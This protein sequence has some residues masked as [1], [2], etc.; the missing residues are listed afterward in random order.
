MEGLVVLIASLIGLA[1][2]AGPIFSVLGFVRSRDTRKRLEEL[3]RTVE[4]LERRVVELSKRDAAPATAATAQAPTPVAAS[5]PAVAPPRRTPPPAPTPIPIPPPVTATA[6][7]APLWTPPPPHV[8]SPRPPTPPPRVEPPPEPPPAP[9]APAFDWESML[10]VRGA[11]WMGGITLVIAAA[12]FAKWSIDQGFFSPAIRIAMMLLAGTGALAWAEL[13]LREGFH[14]TANAVSGAG[15]VT[16]YLAFFAAHSLYQLFGLTVTFAAMMLV[17]GVAAVIAVRHAALFTAV[18]GLV[19]GLATPVLLSTGVDRPLGFF[20]YLVVLAVG[21]LHVA[22]RR[23]WSAI[24]MLSLAGTALLQLG[25]YDTYLAPEKLLVAMGGFAAIGAAYLWHAL[26][27]ADAKEPVAY[28]VSLGGGLVPLARSVSRRPRPRPRLLHPRRGRPR[29]G[30]GRGRWLPRGRLEHVKFGAA[31]YTRWS[32]R[33]VDSGERDRHDPDRRN[34]RRRQRPSHRPH[35]H[36]P[37]RRAAPD[38]QGR[39]W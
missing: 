11:A 4:F 19:G 13:K 29:A 24:T 1:V 34:H 30:P 16:L 25:W 39:P 17:T 21:F 32:G 12:F 28:Q 23:Q 8:A 22:E 14:T 31:R 37:G 33:D 7:A 35:R 20:S 26:R 36:R 38:L 27:V 15:V 5:A 6:P 18:I 9:A 2:L 3:Q 10:G